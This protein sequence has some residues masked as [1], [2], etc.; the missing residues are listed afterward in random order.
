MAALIFVCF[1]LACIIGWIMN[2]CTAIKA[3]ITLPHLADMTGLLIAQLIGVPIA[4]LG[5]ILGWFVW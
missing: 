1:W 3:L 4:P 2:A 5:V